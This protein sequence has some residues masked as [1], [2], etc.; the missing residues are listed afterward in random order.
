MKDKF[1]IFSPQASK[2]EASEG[3]MTF[4]KSPYKVGVYE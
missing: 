3:T 4:K 2:G 1:T